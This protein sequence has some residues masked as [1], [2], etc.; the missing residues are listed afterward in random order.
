MIMLHDKCP[1][2]VAFYFLSIILSRT[3]ENIDGHTIKDIRKKEIRNSYY[4]AQ[5]LLLRSFYLWFY[6]LNNMHL[7]WRFLERVNTVWNGWWRYL[8]FYISDTFLYRFLCLLPKQCKST[9][10]KWGQN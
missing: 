7:K 5:K 9:I 1:L 4:N 10:F 3:L 8:H 2:P 6:W